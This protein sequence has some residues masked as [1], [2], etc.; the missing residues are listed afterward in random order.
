MAWCAFANAPCL[1]AGIRQFH[2]NAWKDP[3][4]TLASNPAGLKL[5]GI[6]NVTLDPKYTYFGAP[7]FPCSPTVAAP[8]PLLMHPGCNSRSFCITPGPCHAHWSHV[9]EQDCL[10]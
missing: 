8:L 4:G 7:H 9:A 5:A 3:N 2:F 10:G 1:P 6:S